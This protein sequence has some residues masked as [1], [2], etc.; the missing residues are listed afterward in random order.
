M[1]RKT[2][3]STTA[4]VDVQLLDQATEIVRRTIVAIGTGWISL[5]DWLRDSLINLE[6]SNMR[7]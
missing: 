5:S 2:T 3:D 1:A 4:G 6:R 7:E